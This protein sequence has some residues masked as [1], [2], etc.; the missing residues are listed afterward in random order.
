MLCRNN[1]DIY[2]FDPYGTYIDD[3][4]EYINPEYN[5][6]IGQGYPFLSNL[7]GYSNFNIHYNPHKLQKFNNSQVCGRYC[8]AFA[9][10]FDEFENMDDFG[11]EFKKYE[12]KG[13]DLD[14][15]IIALTEPYLRVPL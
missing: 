2:F 1:N 10:F 15:V 14:K 9:R 6:L 5:K 11:K 3:Q 7:L 4:L 8:G 13:Y 12:K